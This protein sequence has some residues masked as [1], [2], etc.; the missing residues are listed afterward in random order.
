M[1][2]IEVTNLFIMY[3]KQAIRRNREIDEALQTERNPVIRNML[4]GARRTLADVRYRCLVHYALAPTSP[5]TTIQKV[6]YELA[7]LHVFQS[8]ERVSFAELARCYDISKSG[9]LKNINAC[10]AA[11]FIKRD[12]GGLY[13]A[14]PP[15]E[16]AARRPQQRTQDEKR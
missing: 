15:E 13:V 7:L 11:G 12:K 6:F 5:L 1:I 2:V 10:I 14:G 9:A 3:G 4:K 16:K 8:R